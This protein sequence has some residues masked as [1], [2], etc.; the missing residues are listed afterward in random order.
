MGSEMCIRDRSIESLIEC[1]FADSLPTEP[2]RIPDMRR[3]KSLSLAL[4]LWQLDHEEVELA[5]EK[6]APSAESSVP[7]LGIVPDM[8]RGYDVAHESS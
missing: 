3:T 8:A 4:A 7:S 6:L 5:N 2:V 1:S